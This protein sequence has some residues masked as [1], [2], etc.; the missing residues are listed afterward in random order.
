M[1]ELPP[2]I[3]C[4]AVVPTYRRDG[5]LPRIVE[6]L[7]AQPFIDDIVIWDNN[8]EEVIDGDDLTGTT[9]QP[10]EGVSVATCNRNVC[11]WG[12]YIAMMHTKH[13]WV[14][15]QD[16]DYLVNNWE[17]IYGEGIQRPEQITA[18][19][20]KEPAD[21]PSAQYRV[22]KHGYQALLGWGSIFRVR[23]ISV[24]YHEY[25][26]RHG[27]DFI[28]CREADRIFSVLLMCEHHELLASVVALDMYDSEYALH[29]RDD[30]S[31]VRN[32]AFARCRVIMDEI[33]GIK[34]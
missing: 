25:I 9:Y 14:V 18:S 2:P 1:I 32:Q 33:N 16:D 24:L 29:K 17:E 11:V 22:G 8:W 26:R 21:V 31:R 15:T 27:V 34:S 28:L 10:P 5:N 7:Q 6:S 23:L 19:L 13:D 12:R 30:H 20:F 3:M 4:S